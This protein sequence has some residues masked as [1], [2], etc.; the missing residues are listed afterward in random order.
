MA[1]APLCKLGSGEVAVASEGSADKTIRKFTVKVQT[2]IHQPHIPVFR[3]TAP[4]MLGAWSKHGRIPCWRGRG[5]GAAFLPDGT[6]TS[7]WCGWEPPHEASGRPRGAQSI[8]HACPWH[9]AQGSVHSDAQRPLHILSL[10]RVELHLIFL[11][12]PPAP[13]A[14][15]GSAA[16]RKLG[17]R[18]L[19]P[20]SA[21]SVRSRRVS[22]SYT[23]YFS[24]LWSLLPAEPPA[25]VEG[26][27][28]GWC[29]GY[30]W[31]LWVIRDPHGTFENVSRLGDLLSYH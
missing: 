21:W 31:G 1:P 10:L 8:G 26:A 2:P 12:P 24:R 25:R 23:A 16:P 15:H 6:P 7:R 3:G 11:L 13:E 29:R 4:P 30:R 20:V 9:P 5:L 27:L 28:P 22:S 19:L 18:C 14:Q 17:W